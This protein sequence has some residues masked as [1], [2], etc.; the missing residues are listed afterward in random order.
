ME[1]IISHMS[2]GPESTLFMSESRSASHDANREE[3]GPRAI[4]E[5]RNPKPSVPLFPIDATDIAFRRITYEELKSFSSIMKQKQT[6]HLC[7][8]SLE[9]CTTKRTSSIPLQ[10]FLHVL[11]SRFFSEEYKNDRCTVSLEI[12]FS[13]P[14]MDRNIISITADDCIFLK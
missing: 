13:V 12:L 4:D 6:V 2:I 8:N 11:P 9:C 14:Y 10:G 1:G 5:Q 7:E 3:H